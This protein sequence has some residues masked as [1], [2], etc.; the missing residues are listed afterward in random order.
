MHAP[1]YCLASTRALLFVV[2]F[3]FDI[4]FFAKISQG[5]NSETTTTQQKMSY[6]CFITGGTRGIGRGI[7]LALAKRRPHITLV[8]NYA[9]DDAT[10]IE[11]AEEVTKLAD[12]KAPLLIKAD[13]SSSAEIERIMSPAGGEIIS[14][15]GR[16]DA[17]VLNHGIC[18][19]HDIIGDGGAAKEGDFESW[20]SLVQQ[21]M[22][23]NFD[24]PAAITWF[25]CRQFV[26]QAKNP[27]AC[28]VQKLQ[29]VEKFPTNGRLV[30]ISSRAAVRGELTCPAYAASKA[31]LSILGQSVARRFAGGAICSTVV[32]PGWVATEMA[33]GVLGDETGG[34][35][36][37]EITVLRA[38]FNAATSNTNGRLNQAAFVEQFYPA[39]FPEAANASP[40][41]AELFAQLDSANRG[42]L[43]FDDFLR[44]YKPTLRMQ[45]LTRE[46]AENPGNAEAQKK[47]AAM[48]EKRAAQQAVLAQHP[49][50]RVAQVDEV[51]ET[52]AF[53]AVDCPI[54]ITGT[55][56][57]LNGASYLSH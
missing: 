2:D 8:L 25:A 51:A 34:F 30:Y 35:S 39:A 18:V 4:H 29:G 10:A 47:L 31:A 41:V 37:E 14:R 57:D 24:A 19:E 5:R 36:R 13:L 22:K 23:V 49:L 50:G 6:V 33:R 26:E 54:A 56:I 12:G 38:K 1:F 40:S 11:T 46:L 21:T 45:Q 43:L 20:M 48:K 44:D 32:A 9:R 52:A 16:L 42:Y 55:V 27:S 28:P 53:C 7:A 3:T 15:F 17:V